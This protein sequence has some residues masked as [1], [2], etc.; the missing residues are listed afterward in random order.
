MPR[1][2]RVAILLLAM[3]C[4]AAGEAAASAKGRLSANQFLALD[5]FIIPMM[6]EGDTRRQFTL[7]VALELKDQD[8]RDFVKSQLPLLR[9]RVYDLLFRLIAYRTQE[10]LVPSTSLLKKKVFDIAVSVVGDDKVESIVVQQVY[11]GR[12]P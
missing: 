12:T 6:P 7:V 3:S 4:V 8:D 11:Q 1:L 9:S 5:A 10:P 2:L